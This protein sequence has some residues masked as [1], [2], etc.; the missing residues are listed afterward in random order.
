MFHKDVLYLYL[1]DSICS[2]SCSFYDVTFTCLVPSAFLVFAL[3][4]L[5]RGVKKYGPKLPPS[6]PLE[7]LLDSAVSPGNRFRAQRWQ[8]HGRSKGKNSWKLMIFTEI[9]S[10][11]TCSDPQGLY[12]VLWCI[13]MHCAHFS[14]KNFWWHRQTHIQKTS[15][16]NHNKNKLQ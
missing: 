11:E 8:G 10:M 15:E 9:I 5:D 14:S 12:A 2:Y 6:G 1:F 3:R 7:L 13:V 16:I 4:A